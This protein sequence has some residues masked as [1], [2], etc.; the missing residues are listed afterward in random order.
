MLKVQLNTNY[1]SCMKMVKLYVQNIATVGCWMLRQHCTVYWVSFNTVDLGTVKSIQPAD[2]AT[3]KQSM[4]IRLNVEWL[5]CVY[6]ACV[7]VRCW[8]RIR[9]GGH[10]SGMTANCGT[11]TTTGRT[12]SR[13]SAVLRVSWSTRCSKALTSRHGKVSSGMSTQANSNFF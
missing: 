10:I 4:T 11:W 2:T 12:W 6:G 5:L 1:P 8:S 9:S 7:I 3:T 13:H